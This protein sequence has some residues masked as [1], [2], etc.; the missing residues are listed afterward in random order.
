[1][2]TRKFEGSIQPEAAG[3]PL[4]CSELNPPTLSAARARSCESAPKTYVHVRV[5]MH[6]C[7][8]V[9]VEWEGGPGVC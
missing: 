9:C 8:H 2:P 3:P 7:V 6:V 5:C 1:M 4:S